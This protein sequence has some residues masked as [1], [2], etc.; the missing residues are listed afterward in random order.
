MLVP[1]PVVL[2]MNFRA[3]DLDKANA[4]LDQPPRAQALQAVQAFVF[5][6]SIQSV[7]AF[8]GLALLVQ[9]QHVRHDGLHLVC[10]FVVLNGGL[11]GIIVLDRVQELPVLLEQHV[12]LQALDLR[13]HFSRFDIDDR[14]AICL[15]RR[16]LIGGRQ[17]TVGKVL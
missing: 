1:C 6:V 9:V 15:H 4:C 5:V 11:H 16:G 8:G 3:G 14:Y 12:E 13:I 7:Q 10:H 17:K 2:T